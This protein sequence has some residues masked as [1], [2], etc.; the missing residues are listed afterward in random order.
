MSS[1]AQTG[2]IHIEMGI[3]EIT[4]NVVQENRTKQEAIN[5]QQWQGCSQ[6]NRQDC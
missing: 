6:K 1:L 3:E 2:S 5:P 4:R